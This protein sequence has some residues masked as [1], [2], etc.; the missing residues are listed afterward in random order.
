MDERANPQHGEAK[1]GEVR[2]FR[3]DLA[4]TSDAVVRALNCFVIAGGQFMS[5]D[6]RRAGG[7]LALNVAARGLSS[8]RA[9]HLER[10]LQVTH[11][12][13]GATEGEGRLNSAATSAT[14]AVHQELGSAPAPTC[15]PGQGGFLSRGDAADDRQRNG[16]LP[17]RAVSSILIDGAK[18]M[19]HNDAATPSDETPKADER[20]LDELEQAFP[21]CALTHVLSVTT[22]NQL[23]VAIEIL[24]LIRSEGGVLD[25]LQLG[26]LGGNLAQ[27]LNVTGLRPHQTRVLANRIAALPGVEHAS[28]EHQIL[29]S[30]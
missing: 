21:G 11:A 30:A 29:R 7:G 10:K 26:R 3:L 4:D 2:R 27:R 6:L 12:V 9:A 13:H 16:T 1:P 14:K 19:A 8:E 18:P 24:S 5:L 15:L 22:R 23:D 28:V 25:G 17:L 20:E